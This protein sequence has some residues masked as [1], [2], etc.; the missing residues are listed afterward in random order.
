MSY[1]HSLKEIGT[2]KDDILD[3][4]QTQANCKL[5]RTVLTAIIMH[6]EHYFQQ[7]NLYFKIIDKLGWVSL[8]YR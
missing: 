3:K 5:L 8:G 6:S 2:E 7:Y 1:I 4:Q